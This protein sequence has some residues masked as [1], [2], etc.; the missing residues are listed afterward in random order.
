MKTLNNLS[1]YIVHKGIVD[2]NKEF[3]A[4]WVEKF[5][6]I[7]GYDKESG[8]TWNVTIRRVIIYAICRFFECNDNVN[9]AQFEVNLKR[10]LRVVWN[11]VSNDTA[12]LIGCLQLVRELSEHTTDIYEFLANDSNEIQSKADKAQVEEERE[13]AKQILA[14]TIGNTETERENI[15]IEAE[16]FGFFQ[17]A[18]RFLFQNEE[19]KSDWN[20]F[21]TKWENAKR[22]FEKEGIKKEHQVQWIRNYIK[23]CR[24]YDQLYDKQ[25]FIPN[26]STWK[27]I[28]L[29]EANKATIHDCLISFES[30]TD[31]TQFANRPA[32]ETVRK[33]LCDE[34]LV[35]YLLSDSDYQKFRIRWYYGYIT[36]YAPYGRKHITLDWCYQG[37]SIANNR[38][39][40]F[41]E[42]KND[43]LIRDDKKIKLSD[44]S[45]LIWDLDIQFKYEGYNFQWNTDGNIYLLEN[46]TRTKLVKEKEFV[47]QNGETLDVHLEKLNNLIL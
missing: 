21:E 2:V 4:P 8:I 7:P 47:T 1:D 39:R 9:D 41:N 24:N 20:H 12:N 13:K 37:N 46:S 11:I 43:L 22:Y 38:T 44:G 10:W 6:S 16:N 40:C 14:G 15:I 18:I 26:A 29:N 31:V 45:F 17:G 27:N 5:C 36:L 32:E 19:G 34:Q 30:Y 25:I 33:L 35:K 3:R 42:K 28:L 23:R